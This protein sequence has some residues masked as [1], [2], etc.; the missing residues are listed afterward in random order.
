[1]TRY[2]KHPVLCLLTIR[3][4]SVERGLF[5]SFAQLSLACFLLS[6]TQHLQL[7]NPSCSRGAVWGTESSLPVGLRGERLHSSPR[8]P[9]L[10]C[11]VST[12]H[13]AASTKQ[14]LQAPSFCL[15]FFPTR[16]RWTDLIE[17]LGTQ[18]L[19]CNQRRQKVL[20]RTLLSTTTGTSR[21]VLS[22]CLPGYN[23]TSAWPP[24]SLSP[25]S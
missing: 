23:S 5:K 21:V 19:G 2:V 20:G 17:A 1:M 18:L 6:Y 24:L 7:R 22:H 11:E 9:R 25:P 3:A 10:A 14:N 13:R 12:N 15:S 16:E 4:P 8:A